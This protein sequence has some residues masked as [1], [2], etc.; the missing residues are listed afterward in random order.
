M[1]QRAMEALEARV[2]AV[3]AEMA[4]KMD[5]IGK[6]YPPPPGRTVLTALHVLAAFMGTDEFAHCDPTGRWKEELYTRKQELEAAKEEIKQR[7]LQR[8]SDDAKLKKLRA[9]LKNLEVQRAADKQRWW[10]AKRSW[11]KPC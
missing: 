3:H 1:R 11:Q 6:P 5:N 4:L 7:S 2:A 9:E 10:I 8:I